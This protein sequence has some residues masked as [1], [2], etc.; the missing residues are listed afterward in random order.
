MH[1]MTLGTAA[2]GTKRTNVWQMSAMSK[3]RKLHI[4]VANAEIAVPGRDI[5]PQSFNVKLQAT[6]AYCSQFF[7]ISF[8]LTVLAC[9]S[10]GELLYG[11][12]V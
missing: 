9:R 5:V 6:I 1:S 12:G 8:L 3:Q 10:I 2:F 11:M 4:V 7:W